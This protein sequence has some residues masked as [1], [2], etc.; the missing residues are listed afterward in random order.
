MPVLVSPAEGQDFGA[1]ITRVLAANPLCVGIDPHAELLADW[2]LDDTPEGIREFSLR[3]VRA[4]AAGGVGVIKPQSAFYERHGSR[5]VAVLEETLAAATEA[6]IL[7]VLDV[8]RGD[9]GSTME[10]YA[11][12]YMDPSSP[13]SA[14]A[15]TLSPYLGVG[16]LEPAFAA[17]EEF[18]TGIYVLA[19]TSNPD[20]PQVQ[21][22]T[23][24]AG[25]PVA[26]EVAAGVAEFNARVG[27]PRAG[28]VVGAT[29]GDAAGRLG[30]DL[31]GLGCTFLAPGFGA[32]GA[33]VE[34]LHAVFGAA[35][36]DHRVLVNT[37]RGVLGHG[38]STE[39]MTSEITRLHGV[40]G[41]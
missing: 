4:C 16:S 18:G 33:T 20:G 13:L 38:P 6:G 34:D 23:T 11:A 15:V 37:S 19:L 12:A 32:Q 1:R 22:A 29:I 30:I 7:T 9:I 21:H 36:S 14:D 8:K 10:G 24:T 39:G 28:L 41:E 5:G 31:G 27:S 2:G 35:W 40:L 17:S 26:A 25:N 3:A